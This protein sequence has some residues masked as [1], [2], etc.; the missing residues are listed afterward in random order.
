MKIKKVKTAIL[1]EIEVIDTHYLESFTEIKKQFTRDEIISIV[2]RFLIVQ[3][4][5][6]HRKT[7]KLINIDE[8]IVY[9]PRYED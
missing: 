6:S 2:N 1:G 5:I 8:I 3:A 9:P 4:H 7:G